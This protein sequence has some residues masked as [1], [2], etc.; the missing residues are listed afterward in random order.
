MND[1]FL[2][3]ARKWRSKNFDE[4]IGQELV[5]R[6]LKNSLYRNLIFPVYLFSGPKGCGKTSAARIF[7]AALN[8]QKLQEF[9]QKPQE[10]VVPCLECYS[11]NSMQKLAHPDFIEIDAAS[12]TGVDNIRQVIDAA[13]FVPVI[14][15]KKIYLID[16]SHM[17]S[18]A[19]FNAFLKILEEPP[20]GAVFI[21]ATTDV[22]KILDT[23]K[24]RCFQLFFQPVPAHSLIEH[25]ATLCKKEQIDYDTAALQLIAQETEGSV[26]DALNLI[27]RIRLGNASITKS[28]VFEVL[29]FIDDET[30]CSL[31]AVLMRQSMRDLLELSAN[32]QLKRFNAVLLFK[33]LLQLIHSAFWIKHGLEATDVSPYMKQQLATLVDSCSTDRLIK[34]LDICYS[35]ESLFSKTAM[36]H[37]VLETVLIKLCQASGVAAPEVPAPKQI[38]KQPIDAPKPQVINNNIENS[39]R[40]AKTELPAPETQDKK[41]LSCLAEIDKINDPLVISIFRQG[42]YIA[43]DEKNNKLELIF[44]KKLEF[45]KD[46]LE[47]T[48]NIWHPVLSRFFGNLVELNTQF[49]GAET[50]SKIEQEILPKGPSVAPRNPDAIKVNTSQVQSRPV[51]KKETETPVDISDS[52]KWPKANMLVKIFPGTI[53]TANNNNDKGTA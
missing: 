1:I 27:E 7:A 48:K 24:S 5:V 38:N 9:Q 13:S 32:S 42:K 14:G 12:H 45:F 18:K 35:C 11:C 37:L 33:R 51:Y 6:L 46:W 23:V 34:M 10:T 52:S 3:L 4:M 20:A 40:V 26:R 28:A 39:V 41:W 22:H 8:C 44:S 31:F 47:T 2:N 15:K 29:G 19:A 53:T 50:P 21:L 43:F 17:L 25:L 36:P 30:L 16:E 49:T